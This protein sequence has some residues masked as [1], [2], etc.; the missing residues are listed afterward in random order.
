MCA[1]F[2]M[3]HLVFFMCR[4]F[5]MHLDISKNVLGFFLDF[6]DI[7]S[8]FPR[9]KSIFWKLVEV[10]SRALNTLTRFVVS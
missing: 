7:F 9:T 2:L 4:V 8:F 6:M 1:A 5:K 10:F 3:V